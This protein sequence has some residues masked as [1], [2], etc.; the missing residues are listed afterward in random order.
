MENFPNIRPFNIIHLPRCKS[1]AMMSASFVQSPIP[2]I[3]L[4]IGLRVT[5]F[6][7]QYRRFLGSGSGRGR[8][9]NTFRSVGF[10]LKEGSL[11][12]VGSARVQSSLRVGIISVK[13]RSGRLYQRS[14]PS[15]IGFLYSIG[16]NTG[17]L[18]GAQRD[19]CQ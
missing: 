14:G 13:E 2:G 8:V 11:G 10:G 12:Q 18:E 9:R 16:L 19:Q 4:V 15:R 1:R 3:R 5:R 7:T 17:L 6:L